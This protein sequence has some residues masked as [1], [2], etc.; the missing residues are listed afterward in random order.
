VNDKDKKNLELIYEKMNHYSGSDIK[1]DDI[2]EEEKSGEIVDEKPHVIYIDIGDDVWEIDLMSDD[3]KKDHNN[4][5]HKIKKFLIYYKNDN[6]INQ[7]FLEGLLNS[8]KLET[9]LRKFNIQPKEFLS[10]L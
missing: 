1:E 2:G 6:D 8:K 3:H 4:L 5:L 9:Y 7:N 10:Q